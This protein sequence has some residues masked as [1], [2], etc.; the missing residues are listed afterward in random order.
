MIIMYESCLNGM[1]SFT[2]FVIFPCNLF[3]TIPL[4]TCAGSQV[5][6]LSKQKHLDPK[7]A[8]MKEFHL[9]LKTSHDHAVSLMG[10]IG[11]S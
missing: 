4:P 2:D 7:D 11:E 1:P 6:A 10:A 8:E 5:Q 9:L 3:Y